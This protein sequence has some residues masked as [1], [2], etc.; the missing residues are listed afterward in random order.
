M[1]SAGWKALQAELQDALMFNQSTISQ[2]NPFCLLFLLL[3]F[4]LYPLSPKLAL[5][6]VTS[7]GLLQPC[8]EWQPA[9]LPQKLY[10]TPKNHP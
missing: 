4:Q 6:P 2:R 3:Q 9:C 8:S 1:P 5:I 10:F 7:D